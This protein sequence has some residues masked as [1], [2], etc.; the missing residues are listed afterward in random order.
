MSLREDI[1]DK[2][3]DDVQEKDMETV[4]KPDV[5]A[6]DAEAKG[7]KITGY[8]NYTWWQTIKTFWI[9][10]MYCTMVMFAGSADYYT[11]RPDCRKRNAR[12]WRN[13]E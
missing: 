8:E 3:F 5:I 9:A 6:H 10:S 7:Q 12:G 11:V 4:N 2:H 13:A 1:E